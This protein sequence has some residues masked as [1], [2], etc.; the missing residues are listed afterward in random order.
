MAKRLGTEAVIPDYAAVTNAVG[1]VAGDVSV[2]AVIQILPT[3]L[4]DGE[5]GFMVYSG[6]GSCSFEAL[7]DAVEE[8]IRLGSEQVRR[9]LRERGGREDLPLHHS[10]QEQTAE[11][12]T[13]SIYLGT[14]VSV[15][16]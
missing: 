11:A 9:E 3:E 2:K 14:I 12:S 15:W 6:E 7:A 13:N 10:V 1:A 5:D 8:A 4:P 16:G